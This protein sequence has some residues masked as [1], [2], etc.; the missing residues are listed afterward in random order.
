[1][2]ISTNGTITVQ[3]KTPADV[4]YS[5]VQNTGAQCV[6]A[7]RTREI[8]VPRNLIISH[9][10]IGS[11][12]AARLRSMVKFTNN[13]E[14]SALEG[15]IVEQRVHVVFDTPLRIITK[16]DVEDVMTQL[17]NLLGSTDFVDKILNKEV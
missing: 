16:S 11:G 3:D 14:N 7:D 10:S 8:G 1:M 5:E 13:V 15:D 12:D 9:Q 17:T 6:Y 4:N 2:A